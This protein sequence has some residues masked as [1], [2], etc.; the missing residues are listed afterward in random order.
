MKNFIQKYKYLLIATVAA[1]ITVTLL[2]FFFSGNAKKELQK[3]I[4]KVEAYNEPLYSTVLSHANK[5]CEN[6][7][8]TD[9]D[10]KQ[11]TEL[12]KKAIASFEKE[13]E[14]QY[15][16]D[17]LS[18]PGIQK[19]TDDDCDMHNVFSVSDIS[20]S[21]KCLVGEASQSLNVKKLDSSTFWV[22]N[23]NVTGGSSGG[24]MFGNIFDGF[25][26]Q[27]GA[28]D[29]VRIAVTDKYCLTP[30][31]PEN[32]V[33]EFTLFGDPTV[34]GSLPHFTVKYRA[35]DIK[36][37]G[38]YILLPFEDM[39]SSWDE[40]ESFATIPYA[41]WYNGYTAF[42]LKLSGSKIA[43]MNKG[44]LYISDIQLY[45][46][47]QI[48]PR[49]E[50][51]S[52]IEE[53]ESL[54]KNGGFEEKLSKLRA[55]R[56]NVKANKNDIE[57]AMRDINE[58]ILCLKNTNGTFD[59]E[60]TV[61]N[62]GVISPLRAE[63]NSGEIKLLMIGNSFSVNAY[64]YINQIAQ[65]EGVNLTV[66]NL[67]YPGC[68]LERHYRFFMNDADEYGY[69]RSWGENI[70][71]YSISKALADQEW[72]YISI[73]QV[74]GYSGLYDTSYQPYLS[75]IVSFLRENE[76]Q[77][78]II[79]HQT[80]AYQKTSDHSDFPK[81]DRDQEK[82]WQAIESSSK[83]AFE[84][85]KLSFIVP[86]G[87]AFQIARSSAIGDNLNSDG[88]HANS[89][90]EYI[91]GYCFFS[92]VTGKLPSENAYKLEGVSDGDI[93]LLKSA[94]TQAVK[95]YGCAN[96]SK[97]SAYYKA[98]KKF[99]TIPFVTLDAVAAVGELSASDISAFVNT[100][101][102]LLPSEQSFVS[103]ISKNDIS[104]KG[105]PGYS[106]LFNATSDSEG[107]SNRHISAGNIH[108]LALNFEKGKDEYSS[109]TLTWLT[110]E[111]E[112]LKSNYPVFVVTPYPITDG[113][114]LASILKNHGNAIS[115]SDYGEKQVTKRDGFTAVSVGD[116]CAQTP[117]ASLI[118]VDSKG[119]VRIRFF[120]ISSEKE[121]WHFIDAK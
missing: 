115:L 29:G 66:A 63:E 116:L 83:K 65:A 113:S 45:S 48:L 64:S 40:N 38:G 110:S 43:S 89:L 72:D 67:N 68:S 79:W 60:S 23:A 15:Y 20:I 70:Y 26:S 120:D 35:E 61:A 44:G 59:S 87:R 31:L 1:L 6:P 94:V 97:S 2:F 96:Y 24:A 77:A 19:W 56:D 75:E 117:T 86:S 5:A 73:Q 52:L 95:E 7:N 32:A 28:F 62:I 36:F 55:V 13:R 105:E 92:T 121:E 101:N 118:S 90:G 34:S 112:A 53:A 102:A 4:D 21:N 71:N 17:A 25:H 18:V 11:A 114:E 49:Q 91:A 81:Y 85:E 84:A 9:D 82:M 69:S 47:K 39:V 119:N 103:S 93:E 16:Y 14:S 42:S 107:F 8:A 57:S 78:E 99:T 54:N 33:L 80:W 106:Q 98:L 46:Q 37:F 111:L 51:A 10:I 41:N 50:L 109:D 27:L 3:L 74:S 108:I 100:T 30:E 88:Y 76:P 22:S 104:L 12:L 58:I